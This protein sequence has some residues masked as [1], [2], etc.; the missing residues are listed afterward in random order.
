MNGKVEVAITAS[1]S[2]AKKSVIELSKVLDSLV[3]AATSASKAVFG[4]TKNLAL[5]TVGVGKFQSGLGKLLESMNRIVFYRAIRT[6]IRE[7]TQGFK[8]GVNNLYQYSI[9]LNNIDAG[10]AV[11]TMNEFATT[12]L[13]VKN[14]LGAALMPILNALVPVVISIANAFVAAANAV[15]QFIHALRGN[16]TFTKAKRYAVEYADALDNASGSAK[17]L[18]KQVFGFDELNIFNSPS[19]GGGGG[20]DALDYS[21]MF[22]ESPISN[23]MKDLKAKIEEGNWEEIGQDLANRVNDLVKNIDTTGLGKRLGTK[24]SNAFKLGV[25]FLLTFDFKE[26]GRK[27]AELM[28]G[29][30]D[31][32][33]FTD[34]GTFLAR[35]LTAVFD[36]AMGFIETFDFHDFGA[37]I[38]NVV[39]GFFD[40]L[41]DW[42]DGV[43]WY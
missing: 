17:E 1:A 6:V 42:L 36:F 9:A 11:W 13:Y 16:D 34:V 5:S 38:K 20:G 2:A 4:F 33:D 18:K 32:V 3:G 30:F 26:V 41:S 19:S 27:V 14:S 25:N 39:V 15:N 23:F 7:I 8:E 43:D 35:K 37:A 24:I 10:H 40:H 29:I 22:E 21:E 28:N 12:A 31:E